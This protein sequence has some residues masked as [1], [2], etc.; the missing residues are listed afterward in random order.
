MT[1]WDQGEPDFTDD[2]GVQC[3]CCLKR[4][5]IIKFFVETHGFL[6][7][8]CYKKAE[9]CKIEGCENI[10]VVSDLGL[11]RNCYIDEKKLDVSH[12]LYKGDQDPFEACTR[13]TKGSEEE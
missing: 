12:L 2:W 5:S 6:C 1:E 9:V 11:C 10:A 13:V 8:K 4:R 3:S 7:L